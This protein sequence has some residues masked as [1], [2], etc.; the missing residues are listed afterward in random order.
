MEFMR[1]MYDAKH[2]QNLMYTVTLAMVYE[3][4]ERQISQGAF[5]VFDEK[6]MVKVFEEIMPRYSNLIQ[7]MDL[8][9]KEEK[10][11]ATKLVTE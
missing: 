8:H 9:M 2:R 7:A 10:S 6:Q 5:L 11:H 4:S 1:K 3:Y